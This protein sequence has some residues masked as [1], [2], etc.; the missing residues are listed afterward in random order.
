MKYKRLLIGEYT[1]ICFYIV[2]SGA[3]LTLCEKEN[4]VANLLALH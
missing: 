1:V 3:L 4:V 2:L